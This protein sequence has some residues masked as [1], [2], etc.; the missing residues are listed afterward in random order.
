VAA[1]PDVARDV[2][3]MV[4]VFHD[5]GRGMTKAWAVLGWRVVPADVEYRQLPAVAAVEPVAHAGDG[6]GPGA[7]PQVLFAGER[8][9]FAVPVMAEVYITR[10]LD[11]DAFRRH[12]DRHRTRAAILRHLG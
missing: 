7:A 9:G 8:Y 11:R 12:C 10:V 6:G 2:R 4:P 5:A 3:A 1:D